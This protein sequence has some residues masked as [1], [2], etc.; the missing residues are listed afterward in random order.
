MRV[1][2]QLF[3]KLDENVCDCLLIILLH[4]LCHETYYNRTATVLT[5]D[6]LEKLFHAWYKS[7]MYR[8]PTKFDRV[9][10]Y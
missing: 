7:W 10:N 1:R 9:V 4:D 2:V 5:Q 6:A 8:D 3:P